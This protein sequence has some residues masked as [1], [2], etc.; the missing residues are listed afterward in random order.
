M[1]E[2]NTE[3]K[4]DPV[5]RVLLSLGRG[6]LLVGLFLYLLY[7]LTGGF[8]AEMRT[9]TVRLSTEAMLV[10]G[11]GTVVRDERVIGT[12]L[13]GV[14]GYRYPDGT[15]VPIGAKVAVVYSGTD[16]ET[17]AEIAEIDRAIDLLSAAEIREDTGISDGTAADRRLHER[18][19]MLSEQ[20]ARGQ[21]ADAAE[22][23]DVA[24]TLLLQRDTI[25][26]GGDAAG[27]RLAA[28]R[29]ERERL[30]LRLGGSDAVY[31]PEAGYFYSETDGG[32]A[33]FDF[34]RVESLTPAEYRLKLS[35]F[36][37]PAAESIG[38]M[39]RSSKWYLLMPVPEEEAYGLAVGKSYELRLG[40]AETR[41]SMTLAAKN[42]GDGET[43]LVLSAH[44]MPEG[45]AF[46]R[47]Q[48]VSLVRDTVS[49]YRIPSSALRMVDGVVGVYI[50]SGNTVRFRVAD[51]LHE[52]GTYVFID[53]DTEGVTL[54]ATDTDSE[55]D[56]Y[57]AGLSLYDAVIVSGARD[58]VP[59]GIVK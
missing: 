2:Q 5:L 3:K 31:A 7:H 17:A 21:Y 37:A 39:V 16:G 40:V 30:A 35:A 36:T 42:E 13:Y 41:F 9:E 18:A 53:P 48:K 25:L 46:D 26:A 47:T 43:L 20:L 14:V 54:Y 6:L 45:F 51:V 15:R 59:E 11:E 52:S 19:R 33:A 22:G 29:A 50:R 49:G 4:R 1:G 12:S 10:T 56:L 24:L 55:N 34:S 58:L 44:S 57:C 28:L 32:E 8:A 38:K 23:A 27:D